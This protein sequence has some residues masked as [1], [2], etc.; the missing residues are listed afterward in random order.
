MTP[1]RPLPAAPPARPLPVTDAR[2]ERIETIPLKVRLDRPAAGATL[3]LTHRCTILTRV[4]TNVGVVGE[5]FNGNDDEI[6]GAIIRLIHD[7]LEPRLKGLS[8]I[9]LEEAWAAMRPATEPFLRDRRVPLRAQSCI[10]SAL[11]D[12]VGKLFGVPLHVLWGRAAR[13]VRTVALGGYYR[14]RDELAGLAEEVAELKQHGVGGLKLKVGG[15][16]PRQDAERVAAVRRAAGDDFI[17]AADANQ[18]WTREDAVD[19]AL[20]TADLRL[21]WFEEPCKWD[22]DRRDMA[23][24]R[25]LGRV[26]VSAG[27]SELS[28]FG[29][30]DLMLADAIDICNFDA[31][32]GG[33]P[34]E[35]RRVAALAASFNI[36]MMQ[37]IEPQIGL[38][39]VGGAAN[40]RFGEVMLPWRDPFFYSLIANNEAPFRDG[41]YTLPD[42][43]G[44]G[45]RFDTD[46]LKYARRTD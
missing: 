39:L 30:R 38:M 17:V 2:I 3:K 24:V 27:Q 12:A 29:C 19:F 41:C 15:R 28:R 31:S 36:G 7:E 9:G 44:W 43:P 34:T 4:H 14:E 8:V 37:H 26:P 42:T 25:M 35:W 11:H 21:A 22:N 1:Q 20:R 23:R 13:E 18:G 33:G 32:W 10:D 16:T 5:C 45:M 6:Q 46:Y 40:G